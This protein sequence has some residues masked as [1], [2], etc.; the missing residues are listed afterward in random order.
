MLLYSKVLLTSDSVV[1]HLH[2]RAFGISVPF[3]FILLKMQEY[4]SLTFLFKSNNPKNITHFKMACYMPNSFILH[5][6]AIQ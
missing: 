2:N 1:C 3:T 4:M 6:Q 5:L